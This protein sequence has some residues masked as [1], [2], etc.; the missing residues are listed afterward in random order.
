[1][2]PQMNAN[3]RQGDVSGTSEQEKLNLRPFAFICGCSL[4]SSGGPGRDPVGLLEDLL[5]ELLV[6]RGGQ[7]RGQ[8]ALVLTWLHRLPRHAESLSGVGADGPVELDVR[9]E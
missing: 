4:F 9:H 2:E 8:V 1:M 6:L 5:Q 7:L 3:K